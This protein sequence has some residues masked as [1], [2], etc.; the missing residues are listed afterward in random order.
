MNYGPQFRL[1]WCPEWCP[2]LR[3]EIAAP[4]FLALRAATSDVL[5]MGNE[6]ANDV[7]RL[8]SMSKPTAHIG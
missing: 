6:S 8:W 2:E 1:E 7:T 3:V 4:R 5:S